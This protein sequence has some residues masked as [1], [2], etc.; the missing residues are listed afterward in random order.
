MCATAVADPV[1]LPNTRAVIDVPAT[2]AASPAPA[3]PIV[4]GYRG[5]GGVI[6]AVTRAQLPNPEAYR[7]AARDAYAERIERG[8]AAGVPGYRRIARRLGEQHGTPVL[9]LEGRRGDGATVIVRVALFWTYALALAI[10][11][12]PGADAAAARAVA[13]RFGPPAP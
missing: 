5:P 12:P 6:A 11:V 7:A 13:S 10:E 4:A 3:Y 8:L 2:W 1:K 9:D